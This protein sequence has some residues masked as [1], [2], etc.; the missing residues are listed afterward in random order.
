MEYTDFIAVID[1]GTSHIVGMVGTKNQDDVLSIIAYDS[2]KSEACV[3]RGCVYNGEE[4]ANKVIR[5]IKKLE[6]KLGGSKIAKLYIGVGGQSVRTL[7]HMVS[8]TLGDEGEVTQDLLRQLE[9]ECRNY[10]PSSLDI[11]DIADPVYVLDGKEEVNPLSLTCSRI[12]AHYK[13][14]VGKPAI[15]TSLMTNL[16]ERIKI[17]VVG[18]LLSPLAL[19][20]MFMSSLDKRAAVLIDFGAGVTSVTIFKAGH[21]LSMTVIPLGAHL[22]TRDLMAAFNVSENEAER[23]KRTYGSALPLDLAKEGEKVDVHKVDDYHIQEVPLYD[24]NEVVEARSREIL[25]NVYARLEEAGIAKDS[26]FSVTITGAGSLLNHLQEAISKRFKMSVHYPSV[27]DDMMDSAAKMIANN[28]EFA[29]AVALLLKGKENCAYV[30]KPEPKPEPKSKPV[31]QP[32]PE[33]VKSPLEPSVEVEKKPEEKAATAQTGNNPGSGRSSGGTKKTAWWEKL[34][35]K[36]NGKLDSSD[37]F[38]GEN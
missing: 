1:L 35:E 9:D 37:L 8:K 36:I 38:G 6:N 28:Q 31:P 22:I 15:K 24:I 34:G 25:E 30:Y 26:S 19:S 27:R 32:V 17:P 18:L 3:R 5:L 29:T 12:E 23:L 4:T 20:D 13:L 16:A 11:L 2:E 14:I 7:D 33:F 10:K 21:L